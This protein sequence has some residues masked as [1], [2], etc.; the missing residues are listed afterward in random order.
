MTREEVTHY[1]ELGRRYR[2]VS[3][4]FWNEIQRGHGDSE[5]VK[6]LREEKRKLEKEIDEIVKE[7][8]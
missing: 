4:R 3:N 5:E 1:H 6:T 8:K 2:D 7:R